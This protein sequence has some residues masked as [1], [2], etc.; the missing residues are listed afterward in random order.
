MTPSIS[1]IIITKNEEYSIRQCLE[2]VSWADEIIIVDSHSTDKTLQICKEF[3][4]KIYQREWNGFGIQKNRA[5]SLA[6]KK[7]IF[8]ID[9]DERITPALKEEILAIISNNK[10]YSYEIPRKSYYCGKLIN[11]SGWNPDYVLRLF[12]KGSCNFT[13]DLVHEKLVSKLPIK[14][15]DNYLIHFSFRNFSQVLEKI[16]SY[17]T[18]ASEQL[19]SKRKSI[20]LFEIFFHGFWAFFKTYFLKLGFLDGAHGLFLALSNAQGSYYKYLKLWLATRKER[21]V[22]AMISVI[23]ST[24]NRPDAL[25]KVI[26]SL[27][28]QDD[29][30][31]EIIIADDGS[32]KDTTY[33]IENFSLNQRINISHVWHDDIGFRLSKIRNTAIT[34]A[35]GEYVIFLD[36]DCIVQPDFIRR[37]RELAEHKYVV[38]G[39]RILMNKDLTIDV[40]NAKSFNFKHKSLS[41]FFNGKIN[42]FVSLYFKIPDNF[43][44]KYNTF[45]WKRIKGCNLAVWK[46]D[47]LKIKGFDEK[48]TGWGHEDADFVFRLFKN[49]INRKSG[50]FATEVLHLWHLNQN[51]ANNNLQYV[52]RKMQ[53]ANAN[54]AK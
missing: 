3:K 20:Y 17:S 29:L 19:L 7:W 48:I 50:S 9:A 13:D 10:N 53:N 22:P 1:V 23:V 54:K 14:R 43:L 25:G 26:E 38:T 34:K 36:G 46:I 30:D 28:R 37:H 21:I 5:L 27:L 47:A 52:K 31:Y 35:K 4:A 12:K 8:S 18:A 51:A 44:R 24:Y 40:L 49:G 16:N 45:A 42:K 15:M 2:S 39:G 41:L 11:Y 33:L 32:K 6:T